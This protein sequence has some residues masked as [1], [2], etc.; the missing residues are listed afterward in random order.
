MS[1]AI[2]VFWAP[3]KE[4][5][6]QV[7]AHVSVEAEYGEHVIE[8]RVLTL[9]HHQR[10][11]AYSRKESR[12]PCCAHAE[13]KE[14]AEELDHIISDGDEL[15]FL[16]SHLDLDTIGGLARVLH[17]ATE[18]DRYDIF[19]GL[20]DFWA[21]AESLD[22]N[23]A[24]RLGHG[25]DAVSPHIEKAMY[26]WMAWSQENREKP[27]EKTKDVFREVNFAIGILNNILNGRDSAR[28]F[29]EAGENFKLD[30][31]KLDEESFIEKVDGVILRVGP[32]FTN[33]L[34]RDAEAV[35]AFNTI[36]GSITIS[37]AYPEKY[38]EVSCRDIVQTIWGDEAGGHDG[39][40]GSPRGRRMSMLSLVEVESML[41]Q[42]L[43]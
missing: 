38:P 36:N 2:K 40:A 19:D 41:I 31:K 37:L 18:E 17:A 13:I 1:A 10:E 20:E 3:T 39:I 7:K 32:T 9:A 22:L 6:E 12:A 14:R 43:G 16:I 28:F 27:P 25:I 29:I 35:V 15:T 42:A 8:G 34:Y 30:Q 26:A 24:H 33:H 4:E 23:G 21:L 5:A 11:G